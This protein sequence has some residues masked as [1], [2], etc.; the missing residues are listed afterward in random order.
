[1]KKQIIKPVV[2]LT[3]FLVAVVFFS[4]IT[5]KDNKDLTTTLSEA[6]LPVVEFYEGDTKVCWTSPPT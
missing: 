6:T 3:L 4:V 5:N 2:L 1:M